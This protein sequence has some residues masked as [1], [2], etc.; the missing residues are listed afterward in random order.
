MGM[1]AVISVALIVLS[2]PIESGMPTGYEPGV[3]NLTWLAWLLVAGR[4]LFILVAIATA[5]IA[6]VAAL[7]GGKATANT[8]ILLGICAI[9]T[10][11]LVAISMLSHGH[12]AMWSIILVGFFN[13]IM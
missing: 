6:L 13:S 9:S 11:A 10:S 3:P 8:G 4:P 12:M 5:S 2:Y 7:R 1:V